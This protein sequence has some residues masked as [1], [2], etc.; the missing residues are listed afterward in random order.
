MDMW[1][2]IVLIVICGFLTF[3]VYGIWTV[4]NDRDEFY[5]KNGYDLY[6]QDREMNDEDQDK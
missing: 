1:Q 6:R 2:I 4:E 3:F 5:K